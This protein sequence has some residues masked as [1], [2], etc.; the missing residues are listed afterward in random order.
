MSSTPP[1]LALL[2]EDHEISREIM[3]RQLAALGLQ[4]LTAADGEEGWRQWCARQ[5][6]LVL[7]DCQ[8]PRLDG[9]ALAEKIRAA[10][11]RQGLPR[12]L[13]IAISANAAAERAACQQ[14]GMDDCLAKPLKRQQLLDCLGRLGWP[15]VCPSEA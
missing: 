3:A 9:C 4:V 7:A 12:T 5:P 11:A 2:C 13:L 15:G 6:W 10:E 8:M 1:A 14:A